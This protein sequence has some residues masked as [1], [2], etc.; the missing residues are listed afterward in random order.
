MALEN[1][2]Q[3]LTAAVKAL[4]AALSNQVDE[5]QPEVKAEVKKT[6]AKPVETKSTTESGETTASS[7]VTSPSEPAD[8]EI[9]LQQLVEKFTDLVDFNR[10]AAVALLKEYGLPKLGQAK[11][12][13]YVEIF[14]K[15]CEL[16]NG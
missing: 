15:T 16:L 11:P 8:V 14:N 1:D 6:S 7:V 12:E 10:S 5:K 2:I 4:T 13:Q 3:E 9:T